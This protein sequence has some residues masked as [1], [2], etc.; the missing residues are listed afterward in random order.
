M[1]KGSTRELRELH[2][3]KLHGGYYCMGV[4]DFQDLGLFIIAWLITK[5][6]VFRS[7]YGLPVASCC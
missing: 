5:N 7:E 3:L 2:L 6:Y 4:Y 1:R